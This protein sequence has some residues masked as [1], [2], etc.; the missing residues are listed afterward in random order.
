MLSAGSL[1]LSPA[2]R[3]PLDLGALL[4]P[5]FRLRLFLLHLLS[6]SPL[7][8]SLPPPQTELMW[9]E[10]APALTSPQS[11][12]LL[13]QEVYQ[14]ALKRIVQAEAAV[15]H[16]G[17]QM[18]HVAVPALLVSPA[19]S[20]A[21][22]HLVPVVRAAHKR[23]TSARNELSQNVA[24]PSTHA[25]GSA[26][27]TA[28]VVSY[29]DAATAQAAAMKATNALSRTLFSQ[30]HHAVLTSLGLRDMILRIHGELDELPLDLPNMLE[31]HSQCAVML[32]M[33]TDMMTLEDFSSFLTQGLTPEQLRARCWLTSPFADWATL[34]TRPFYLAHHRTRGP[35]HVAS[36]GFGGEHSA[37]TGSNDEN[38]RDLP[39]LRQEWLPQANISYQRWQKAMVARILLQK[40]QRGED[41]VSLACQSFAPPAAVLS[42]SLPRHHLS[43]EL[44]HP[45]DLF[46]SWSS[47]PLVTPSS[48]DDSCDASSA[49]VDSLT[50]WFFMLNMNISLQAQPAMIVHPECEEEVLHA[51][52]GVQARRWQRAAEKASAN[53][54]R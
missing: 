31:W 22:S 19:T 32:I 10:R 6:V 33:L 26:A 38:D 45:S 11:Q 37:Q 15:E 27:P 12:Y 3:F 48:V 44:Q 35:N 13:L 30:L 21:A 5:R 18:H 39:E 34:Q 40:K 28:S 29:S 8:P 54:E 51:L 36:I 43:Q 50:D 20:S 46:A 2:P 23:N 52:P 1:S 9:Q 24:T 14:Q 25:R 17:G 53:G 42:P 49:G 7:Q 47:H 41:V 16:M 4:R